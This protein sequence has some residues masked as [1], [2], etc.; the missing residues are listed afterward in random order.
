MFGTLAEAAESRPSTRALDKAKNQLLAS[1]AFESEGVTL[2][3]H[4][5]GYF[6]TIADHRS[7]R[8]PS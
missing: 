7:L 3:A 5:L 1:L 6:A 2:T 4:Q 8:R